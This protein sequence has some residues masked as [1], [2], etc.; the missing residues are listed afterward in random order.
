MRIKY[1]IIVMSL[2]PLAASAEGGEA[3]KSQNFVTKSLMW[4]KTLIDS[5]AVASIDRSYIEQPKLPWAVELR[6]SISQSY[7]K[8][9]SDWPLPEGN[10]LKF[11]A[12]SDNGFSTSVGAWVGYRG[13]GF[14]LSKELSSGSGSTLSFGAMGG[15]FGINLRINSY[16][17]HQPEVSID[18]DV[19]GEKF[20]D[21]DK[22]DLDDPIDVRTLFID[23][24][25]MF[26]GKHFSYAAAYDQSLIQRR[27]AGSLVAGL[28]Y[29]HSKMAYDDQSNW[30]LILLTNDEGRVT[31][32]Q[33]NIG[34]GYAYN[35]VPAKGWLVSGMV[36]P[37]LTFYNRMNSYTYDILTQDG[38]DLF[39]LSD[40]ELEHLYEDEEA[41][42]SVVV[43]ESGVNSTRNKVG[44]NF[45]ARLSVV[46]N[47]K[48]TYLRVYG[49]YNRFHYDNDESA[50]RLV[51]WHVY[52]SLGYRF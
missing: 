46:Y 40:E 15:S 45:D 13:Y 3:K 44:W 34:A 8:V 47:W 41:Y 30:P 9:S 21:R 26:N 49:H 17:S 20:S 14:G 4:V 1:L 39:Q 18:V 50:G 23:G 33:A 48:R 32:T 25:Y 5:M 35:W 27:S 19:A 31:F 36:M 52:A 38:R 7:M 2:M 24:Y 6:T 22:V 28:M 16:R 43:K 51:E 10:T 29:F 11:D 42:R 12:L 37:M